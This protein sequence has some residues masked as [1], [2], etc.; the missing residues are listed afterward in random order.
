ML[1]EMKKNSIRRY[2]INESLSKI[3]F[4]IDLEK[5]KDFRP[6][7]IFISYGHTETQICNLICECLAKRGHTVWYDANDILPGND[8]RASIIDGIVG[9][10]TFVAGLSKHYIRDNSVCLDELSIA[11]GVKKG[12]IKTILLEDESEVC[13]P[14]S[15]RNVQWLDLHDWNERIL[16]ENTFVMW[17]QE[18]MKEL[19]Q[20][21]EAKPDRDFNG[22]ITTLK[23]YLHPNYSISKQAYLLEKL[24]TNREWLN[25]GINNWLDNKNTGK[26]CAVFGNPGSGKSIFAANY[27]H[28]NAR[29]AAAIFCEEGRPQFNSTN[30]IIR[31]LAYQ[32]AC[33]L[34]EYRVMLS[35][36]I[37]DVAVYKMNELELFDYL[38]A[39][40][41]KKSFIGGHE[42]MCILVDGL[43]ECGDSESNLLA[44][45]LMQYAERL[46]NW[47]KILIF[48]RPEFSVMAPLA[49]SDCINLEKY[50]KEI[51]RDLTGF[52]SEKLKEHFGREFDRNIIQTIVSK[53]QDV[54]LYAEF[55]T[56]G[57]I[58]GQIFEKDLD[59][60]PP[61]LNSIFYHWFT[62][63]FGLDSEYINEYADA[64]EVIAASKEPL[65]KEELCRICGWKNKK[66][67]SF[68]RKLNGYFKENKNAFGKET[69]EFSHLYIKK[70]LC[71]KSAGRFQCSLEDGIYELAQYYLKIYSQSGC[72]GLTEYGVLNIR[73]YFESVAI[74]V[75]SIEN[76]SDLFWKIMKL[77]FSCDDKMKE[78][79]ALFC[80]QKANALLGENINIEFRSK[81]ISALH[82]CGNSYKKIGDF[83][84]AEKSFSQELKIAQ[85]AYAEKAIA[86]LD[87]LVVYEEYASFLNLIGKY[88][89]SANLYENAI[90][91][92]NQIKE[93]T[94]DEQFDREMY[95]IYSGAAINYRD[96][97]L[98]EKS[99]E[100]FNKG[101]KYLERVDELNDLD[102]RNIL[103]QQ[104]NICL[105]EADLN[106][107]EGHLAFYRKYLEM[108]K[109]TKCL[110]IQAYANTYIGGEYRRLGNLE[111]AKVYLEA[112]YRCYSELVASSDNIKWIEEKFISLTR[113]AQ[114]EYQLTENTELYET[115]IIIGENFVDKYFLPTSV[116]AL[117]LIYKEYILGNGNGDYVSEIVKK[118]ILIA[119]KTKNKESYRM[120][121]TLAYVLLSIC[122]C[123]DLTYL[124]RKSR[125]SLYM[126]AMQCANQIVQKEE[127][128]FFIKWI[129][130]GLSHKVECTDELLSAELDVGEVGALKDMKVQLKQLIDY[131]ER[132]CGECDIALVVSAMLNLGYMH[133]K[134]KEYNEASDTYYK[135]ATL[136][137]SYMKSELFTYRRVYF[138][139]NACGRM[140]VQ[141]GSFKEAI[142]LFEDAVKCINNMFEHGV[143][144]DDDD[145][146]NLIMIKN[147]IKQLSKQ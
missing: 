124:D 61:G 111:E 136:Q 105:V 126:C 32:L 31:V 70:W 89:N 30:N 80:Y 11:I 118:I 79:D 3:G 50:N 19:I 8:W 36:L 83:K 28:Y 35:Y 17:F 132:F 21:L 133:E 88:T 68:V 102:K 146:D 26:L 67:I 85:I 47:L 97:N 141:L 55:V 34:P 130:E 87:M 131:Y 82:M 108:G 135:A 127:K 99:I 143:L 40:P 123:I 13:I 100:Y 116:V 33:R 119:E 76:D 72:D 93:E 145:K 64:L 96:L 92:T 49:G 109:K 24:Y 57:L 114:V 78:V 117:L 62:R 81:K 45:V 74:S 44:E 52:V 20:T 54:F 75:E 22:Q 139:L 14:G 25:Q 56:Q 69:I 137:Q 10:D 46:P 98:L 71:S 63:V 15:V 39:D 37:S 95:R 73:E 48:S 115:A 27:M 142:E 42:T 58:D 59:C 23:K 9:C 29:V 113:L 77:G 18:R 107:W 66:L 5:P 65:P 121:N 4:Y 43:D 110:T 122:E 53:S 86:T 41:L 84:K 103:T 101:I 60:I 129:I 1:E 144:G 140:K 91:L 16:D 120:K 106:K 128:L 134:C 125:I 94:W 12:N 6:L 51:Q 138:A 7:K 112:S 38:I 2:N 104:I 90:K 147:S